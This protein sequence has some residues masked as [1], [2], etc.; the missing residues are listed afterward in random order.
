MKPVTTRANIH[1]LN[2]YQNGLVLPRLDEVAINKMITLI[3]K[4]SGLQKELYQ[5]MLIHIKT[6]LCMRIEEG[7]TWR[8]YEDMLL[9][10]IKEI[11]CD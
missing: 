6:E 7:H 1:E 2:P 11:S 4:D 3:L 8:A 5:K 9:N 10:K